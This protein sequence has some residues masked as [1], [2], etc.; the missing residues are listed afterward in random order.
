[1]TLRCLVDQVATNLA[2]RSAGGFRAERLAS[3]T[4]EFGDGRVE[5]V[6][7]VASFRAG[8]SGWTGP[9]PRGISRLA[10][11]LNNLTDQDI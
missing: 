3:S 6:A 4:V 2:R 7:A 9:V 11:Y 5:V 1:M 8:P 10:A